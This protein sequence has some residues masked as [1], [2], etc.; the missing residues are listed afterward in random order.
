MCQSVP[1]N[2][3]A[4]PLSPHDY[5]MWVKG[6]GAFVAVV[7]LASFF[8]V[9]QTVAAGRQLSSAHKFFENGDFK[10]AANSYQ[11]VLGKFPGS[12]EAHLGAAESYFSLHT[13]DADVKAMRNLVGL[14]LGKYDVER[15]NKVMPKEYWQAFE[16]VGKK[17]VTL[18]K[19]PDS[20]DSTEQP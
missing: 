17:S 16:S 5:P 12:E 20:T 1:P 9:P 11:E 4:K 18:R 2:Y 7:V 15:L 13:K 19:S 8:S 3:D 10:Q 14:K 6:F